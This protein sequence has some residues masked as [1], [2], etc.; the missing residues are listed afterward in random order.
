MH[1]AS[2]PFAY[3]AKKYNFFTSTIPEHYTFQSKDNH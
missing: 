2:G 3:D 1:L